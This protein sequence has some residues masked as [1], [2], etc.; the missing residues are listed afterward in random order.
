MKRTTIETLKAVGALILILAL[1]GIAG[2]YDHQDNII[3]EMKD[4]G[5]YE[6]ILE[7]HP[8]ASE[9][10][11]VKLYQERQAIGDES[12]QCPD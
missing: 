1:L 12:E 5:E 8:G 9:A 6:A 7:A 11:L 3:T 10:E 2:H 4:N